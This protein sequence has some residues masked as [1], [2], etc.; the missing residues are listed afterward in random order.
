MPE[1]KVDCQQ[2]KGLEGFSYPKWV[3]I[4]LL[5]E[6]NLRCRMCYEW[7]KEGSYHEKRGLAQLDLHVIKKVIRD[8]SPGK[9]YF[10]LFGGEPLMY[11]W[12]DEVLQTIRDCGMSVDIP[13][14]GML[15]EPLAEMLVETKP[16][17]LWIS[18]DGPQDINDQQRG[19]G[20]YQKV[21]EGIERLFEVRQT[22]G[23]ELPKIGVTML[24]TPFNYRY[25]EDLFFNCLDM[26]KID[27]ISI[28]FQLYATEQQ[29]QDYAKILRDEFGVEN[30]PGARGFIW[31]VTE[32]ASIDI[33]ELIRQIRN[34]KAFCQERNIYFITY[35]KTIEEDNISRFF[36]ADWGNMVDKRSR[37]SFPWIYMEINA[38][39]DVSPC[40]TFYDLTLGSIYEQEILD[41]W[42]GLR[43]EKYRNYMRKNLLP[44]C[45]AC[46]RYYADPNKK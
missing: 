38:K 30:A 25:I 27:H 32:F 35:P 6:C 5:E 45:T 33:P 8:V 2:R 15:L 3:V 9:P 22:R 17:R 20:V 42:N 10:G 23:S 34:V 41:I 43:Y 28:E 12:V 26:S 13:T 29:C 46:S 31:N 40:H 4:Q 16:R 1:N 19:K 24:V 21:T 39:G 7:G 14:N 36:S 11:P 18:L 44:I 37:C